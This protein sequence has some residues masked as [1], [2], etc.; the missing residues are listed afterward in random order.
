MSDVWSTLHRERIHLGEI[1]IDRITSALL[2]YLTSY[3]GLTKLVVETIIFRGKSSS[4]SDALA[5]VFFGKPLR[6][7]VETL[8][9]LD[10]SAHFRDLWCFG[11]HNILTF[12]SCTNLR[13][14]LSVCVSEA[15]LPKYESFGSSSDSESEV[16]TVQNF[17]PNIVSV[18]RRPPS[19]TRP[20]SRKHCSTWCLPICLGCT[21]SRYY[22]Q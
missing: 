13:K 19:L 15:D 18:S 7:H 17:E 1:K 9:E 20:R 2:E 22:L 14:L 4:E 8:E 10:I 16:A 11:E 3:T 5:T 6:S 21:S 12:S